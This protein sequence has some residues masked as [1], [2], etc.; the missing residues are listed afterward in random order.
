MRAIYNSFYYPIKC[1]STGRRVELPK[2][3]NKNKIAY[4]INLECEYET[5]NGALKTF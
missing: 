2:P 1:D 4:I 5:L 3:I